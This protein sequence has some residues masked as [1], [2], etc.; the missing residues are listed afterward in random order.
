M[1]L[2][3]RDQ[4]GLLKEIE[5]DSNLSIA[6]LREQ[7]AIEFQASSPEQIKLINKGKLLLNEQTISSSNLQENDLVMILIMKSQEEKQQKEQQEEQAHETQISQLVAEGFERSSAVSALRRADWDM[8][9]AHE[10][11]EEGVGS[12]DLGGLG[13]LS[14]TQEQIEELDDNQLDLMI[15]NA[16]ETFL[17]SPQFRSFREQIR[18]NPNSESSLSE[19]IR[20][21][22][23]GFHSLIV[24][25]PDILQEILEGV[26]EFTEEQLAN[27]GQYEDGDGLDEDEEWEELDEAGN[28]ISIAYTGNV[29]RKLI[30]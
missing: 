29:N 14:M 26:N 1:K 9:L 4:K 17:T 11:L 30:L 23:P 3:I 13:I 7:V 6:Q 21:I 2:K 20:Q 24:D 5:I 19:L 10:Y 8:D 15:E 25:Y 18:S 28:P 12:G 16:I 27:M 22:S